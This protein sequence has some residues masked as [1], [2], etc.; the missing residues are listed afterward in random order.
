MK[1]LAQVGTLRLIT[2]TFSAPRDVAW[3]FNISPNK[4]DTTSL[5][6][7]SYEAH[8]V[9]VVN[10]PN[11]NNCTSDISEDSR[12]MCVVE[13]CRHTNRMNHIPIPQMG[14]VFKWFCFFGELGLAMS[15]T[16]SLHVYFPGDKCWTEYHDTVYGNV[17]ECGMLMI[18]GR[19]R[20]LAVF[21]DYGQ[22]AL[23]EVVQSSR[24]ACPLP[25]IAYGVKSVEG[26]YRS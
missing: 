9:T 6:H 3:Y 23:R 1:S 12:D 16:N 18:N 22:F 4:T 19:R 17:R 20:F 21:E 11:G 25:L 13:C 24:E 10:L 7:L 15:Q 26:L 14:L 2:T 5:T 8:G